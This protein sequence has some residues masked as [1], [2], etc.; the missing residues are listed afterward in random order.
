MWLGI[1]YYAAKAAESGSAPEAVWILLF[2]V[3]A[4][5]LNTD[6]GPL[7]YPDQYTAM[8]PAILIY[9]W[10]WRVANQRAKPVSYPMRA[11]PPLP[12]AA[13]A[14]LRPPGPFGG[15]VRGYRLRQ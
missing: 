13:M 11:E 8:M 7:P 2:M 6:E 15:P 5:L 10:R 4:I 9:I 3:V 14:T 1:I 12:K